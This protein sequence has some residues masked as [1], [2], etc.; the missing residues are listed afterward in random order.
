MCLQLYK[1]WIQEG[2]FGQEFVQKLRV[3]VVG[4]VNDVLYQRLLVAQ[5]GLSFLWVRAE[6]D[7]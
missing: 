4:D 1:V 3:V 7:L 5:I 6:I 2:Y